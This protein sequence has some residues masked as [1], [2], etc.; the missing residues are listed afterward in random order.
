M[1]LADASPF[2]AG[3]YAQIRQENGDWDSEPADWAQHAVGQIVR[4]ASISE[5]DLTF[6]QPLRIDFDGSL[7]PEIARVMPKS[8]VGIECLGLETLNDSGTGAG[9]NID[10]NY[11]VNCWVKGVESNKSVGSH[12][13]IR[14]SNNI[15]V[16]GCYIHDAF[17]F[18]GSGTR[19]Y[20]ITLTNHSGLCLIENNIFDELRH[21]M[22]VKVGAN[23]NVFGYNYSINPHRSEPFSAYSGDISLHGHYAF[24]NL[25]EGNI[26]QNIMIDHYWGP[27]GPFN[28][29]FR[30]R[31]ELYGLIMTSSSMETDDQNFV[32]NEITGKGFLFPFQKGQYAMSGEGH[33]EYAN[34]RNGTIIP[35]GTGPLDDRSYY[36]LSG[37]G[38]LGQGHPVAVHRFAV[39]HQ[40]WDHSGEG[41]VSSGSDDRLSVFLLDRQRLGGLAYTGELDA[42]CARQ[43]HQRDHFRRNAPANP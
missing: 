23:G 24:S 28:T 32:G 36:L 20:G 19:G 7:N 14:N 9:Y 40:L 16:S 37:P 11:A 26:V 43:Q 22:M 27:S 4:I 21:A 29:L 12:I 33:L 30:N 39:C 5:N 2:S 15:E 35:D 38:I 10:F 18:D 1:S 42:S 3:D 25:F 41:A 8:M 31:A 34:N 17:T 6:E 13:M